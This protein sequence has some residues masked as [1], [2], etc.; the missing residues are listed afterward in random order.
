MQA[1]ELALKETTTMLTS[2]DEGRT[3]RWRVA[4]VAHDAKK[5]ALVAFVQRHRGQF[6][7]WQLLATA[8]TGEALRDATGLRLRTVLP[9][10]CGGDIQIGAE[11]ASGEIDA[12]IFLRDPLTAQP[13]EPDVAAVLRVADVHNVA[14]ATNLASAECLVRAL[15][16]EGVLSTRN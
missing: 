7:D 3:R 8:A 10:P 2:D 16:P 12:L 9:G 5:A 14:L 15:S 11:L 6:K 4:L 13:H 1:T